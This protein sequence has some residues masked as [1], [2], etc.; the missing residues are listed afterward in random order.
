LTAVYKDPV[1]D[2]KKPKM[3]STNVFDPLNLE[4]TRDEED[5]LPSRKALTAL[6]KR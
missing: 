6:R 4:D 2:L 5:E 1:V 3:E